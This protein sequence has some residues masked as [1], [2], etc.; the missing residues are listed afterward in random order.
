MPKPTAIYMQDVFN[1]LEELA[2][3]DGRTGAAAETALAELEDPHR[4]L[5]FFKLEPD[6]HFGLEWG[7][8]VLDLAEADPPTELSGGGETFAWLA[9]LADGDLLELPELAA[10]RLRGS[11]SERFELESIFS[12]FKFMLNLGSAELEQLR[13]ADSRLGWQLDE[14][15]SIPRDWSPEALPHDYE[16]YW[17]RFQTVAAF[18]FSESASVQLVAGL[19][20]ST[21]RYLQ[22]ITSDFTVALNNGRV[23]VT[24][25]HYRSALDDFL[26]VKAPPVSG[27]A[28]I[29]LMSALPLELGGAGKAANLSDAFLD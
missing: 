15:R 1:A 5:C 7:H 18:E 28:D 14:L 8:A 22:A 3:L 20:P 10:V 11:T 24:K 27:P 16:A 19:G 17:T 4:L 9:A 29:I 13:K 23:R 6:R 2:A 25:R 21:Y 12:T 26:D